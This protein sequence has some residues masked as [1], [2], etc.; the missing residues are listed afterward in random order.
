MDFQDQKVPLG[1]RFGDCRWSRARL[2]KLSRKGSP[3]L[4]IYVVK[5]SKDIQVP[6]SIAFPSHY[7]NHRLGYCR[8][9]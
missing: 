7:K 5:M 4:Q 8:T 9:W 2:T 6:N 3:I 1:C